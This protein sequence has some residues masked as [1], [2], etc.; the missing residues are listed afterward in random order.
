MTLRDQ[1]FLPTANVGVV[2]KVP[3][4][5][6]FST[7]VH[8]AKAD[9]EVAKL[10][11]QQATVDHEEFLAAAARERQ[12]DEAMEAQKADETSQKARLADEERVKSLL[13]Y[14]ETL[15]AISGAPIEYRMRATR[16]LTSFVTIDQFPETLHLFQAYAYLKA[17]V[18]QLF[19]PWE[20]ALEDKKRLEA[21]IRE[22]RSLAVRGTNNWDRTEAE[23]AKREVERELQEE[24]K[25]AWSE[26]D[27]ADL[28]D[29][30]LDQ[31]EE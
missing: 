4:C 6:T 31:W 17:K 8:E 1:R 16:E 7:R 28:V 9:L 30:I 14:A 23:R 15:V 12:R 24:V 13:A 27:V 22:G 19:A 3:V 21:L 26:A 10:L 2:T 5:T 18:D 25:A 11:R 20:K 29:D